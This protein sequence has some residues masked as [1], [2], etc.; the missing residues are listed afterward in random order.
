MYRRILAD[1][2]AQEVMRKP[3]WTEDSA[4]DLARHLLVE[5]PKRLFPAV[6]ST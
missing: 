6:R 4:L 5:N 1:V 3:G 2:L